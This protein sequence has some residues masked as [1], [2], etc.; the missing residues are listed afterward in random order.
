MIVQVVT[1]LDR[2]VD[3]ISAGLIDIGVLPIHGGA[4]IIFLEEHM[5]YVLTT[6]G[7]TCPVEILGYHH[8]VILVYG[9]STEIAEI[10]GVPKK[11]SQYE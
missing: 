4:H 2:A 9:D 6:L 5:E 1:C 3:D 10:L 11:S 7:I 8:Q